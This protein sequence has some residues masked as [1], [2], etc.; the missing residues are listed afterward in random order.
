MTSLTKI[1]WKSNLPIYNISHSELYSKGITCLLLDVD[2]TLINRKTN[3]IPIKVKQW[4]KKS[5]EYF[6]LYL[7]SNNPSEKRIS[8]IG[9][10]LGLE[11][12]HKAL[13]PSKKNTLKIIKKLNRDKE[14]I[15]I[16]GDR[17]L[18]D[19]IVGNRCNIH[20]ILVKKLNKN[21]L[22]IKINMILLIE[23]LISFF[24]F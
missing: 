9:N 3:S 22:P 23:R 8:S 17:I 15:A 1:W 2:G 14:N 5:K 24:I 12:K 18:T 16:V 20:T 11:Y 7:I 4:I 10:E 19:I 21:G 6:S 13:K